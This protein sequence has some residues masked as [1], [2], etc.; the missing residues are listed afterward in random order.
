VHLS[1]KEPVNFADEAVFL[2]ADNIWYEVVT[3]QISQ[4]VLKNAVPLHVDIPHTGRR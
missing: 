4:T 1:C 2:L 3:I